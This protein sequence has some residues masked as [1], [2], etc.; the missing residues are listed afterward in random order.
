[1]TYKLFL[2]EFKKSLPKFMQSRSREISDDIIDLMKSALEKD[3]LEIRGK[4][5]MNVG[6]S[7]ERKTVKFK[8]LTKTLPDDIDTKG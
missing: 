1:M 2:E 8:D 7:A 6:E 5:S 3:G 4:F